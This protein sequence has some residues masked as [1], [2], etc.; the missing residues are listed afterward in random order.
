ML[1]SSILQFRNDVQRQAKR[2]MQTHESASMRSSSVALLGSSGI[3]AGATH[4]SYPRHPGMNQTTNGS[5]TA[6]L[7][8]RL[9]DTEDENKRLK[10]QIDKQQL[11]MN[12]YRERWEKLKESAKKR[13]A[14]TPD[15][16]SSNNTNNNDNSSNTSNNNNNSNSNPNNGT[17]SDY[18][19]PYS[20][21]PP[22]LL[23]SLAQ[24]SAT[25]HHPPFAS[26]SLAKSSRIASEDR[27]L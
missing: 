25:A 1:K 18:Q 3:N 20:S 10:D 27:H 12:K 5:S 26:S 6:E 19:R 17:T 14:Q 21:R 23:R 11:L 9:K 13:R 7:V 22:A 2:I 8:T 15:V 4:N 24:Q 16:P